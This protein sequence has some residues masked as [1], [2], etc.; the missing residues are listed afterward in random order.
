MD[1]L[2]A[3]AGVT[4]PMPTEESAEDIAARVANSH[5][6]NDKGEALILLGVKAGLRATRK[7]E[8]KGKCLE[9]FCEECLEAQ[10]AHSYEL[11]EVVTKEG[12]AA[13][14]RKRSGDAYALKNDDEAKFLR[15]LADEFEADA[16]GARGV[17]HDKYI[18]PTLKKA[19]AK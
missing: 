9:D 10:S 14:F 1:E 17:F 13:M 15:K 12:F 3:L 16:K 7:T 4:T 6:V 5:D 19:G 18:A 8:C 11:G 2:R